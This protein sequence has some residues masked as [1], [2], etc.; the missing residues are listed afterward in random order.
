MVIFKGFIVDEWCVFG[1]V[2]ILLVFIEVVV[3]F[4][5]GILVFGEVVWLYFNWNY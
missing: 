2:V 3:L 1:I 5:F 4:C